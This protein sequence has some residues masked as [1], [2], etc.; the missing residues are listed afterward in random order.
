MYSLKSSFARNAVHCFSRYRL[1]LL[2]VNAKVCQRLPMSRKSFIHCSIFSLESLGIFC[3]SSPLFFLVFW[4]ERL[5]HES[6]QR[7]GLCPIWQQKTIC[8]RPWFTRLKYTV[9]YKLIRKF[10]AIFT[11]RCRKEN[12]KL[13]FGKKYISVSFRACL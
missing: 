13:K 3:S 6:C 11:L 10:M 7:V 9:F 5:R 8:H 1:N 4:E 12:E 2:R